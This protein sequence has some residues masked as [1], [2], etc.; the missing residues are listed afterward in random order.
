M[1]FDF[2]NTD[3]EAVKIIEPGVFDDTRGFFLEVLKK[4]DFA[5]SGIDGEIVQINH[6]KSSKG[7]LR[8]LHYQKD[9][10]AQAKLVRVIQGAIFDVAVDIRRGSPTYGKWVG[11][12]LSAENHKMLFVPQ[13]FAHGFC[14]LS[15]T[16]EMVYYISG[17]EY[18]P[19]HDS[20][21]RW[22]DPDINIDWPVTSPLLSEKDEALP[23]LQSAD[24]N[25]V[26]SK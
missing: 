14:V 26:Y 4:S 13:G 25:F 17:G 24:N 1:P 21:L 18:S 16:A 19:E 20:G 22:N 6:S 7:V 3:I 23:L 9:P 15:D 5:G 2:H 11:E 10:M 8:G 12:T